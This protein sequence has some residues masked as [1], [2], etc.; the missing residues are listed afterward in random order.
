MNCETIK[1]K[2]VKN[3]VTHDL[4]LEIYR[5]YGDKNEWMMVDRFNEI[6][7]DELKCLVEYL[8]SLFKKK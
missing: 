6:T 1:F 7:T 3:P 5:P 4:Q 8:L 2:V